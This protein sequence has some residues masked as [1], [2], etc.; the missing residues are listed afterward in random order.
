[1]N[2]SHFGFPAKHHI[3]LGGMGFIGS[4]L[5][6]ELIRLNQ[7]CLVIDNESLGSLENLSPIATHPNLTTIS[8]DALEESTW[9]LASK[10]V[11][12]S[13][14]FVWHLAANSD[15]A[16]GST[17]SSLDVRNTLMST[18]HLSEFITKI[19][20]KGVVFAS[21]SAVYG[22]IN[23][24]DGF[25]EDQQCQP[26][27]YYGAT[28]LA[29]EH[30]L[31]IAT[32]RLSIPLWIF[33]FAN[34]VGSPATHGVI[35][36][37]LQKLSK[38][39]NDLYILG[40]GNQRK[41]YLGVFHLISCML[42]LVGKSKSGVWNM[43]P[44]DNGITVAEI[45][46]LIT[47][48]AAPD[49]KLHFGTDPYGWVGDISIAKMNCFKLENEMRKSLPGSELAVHSAIHDIASQLEISFTCRSV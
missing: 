12:D 17:S 41:T 24:Q 19:N 7:F 14:V 45:A 16:A 1:M 6:I 32:S 27:S 49:A 31:E 2:S 42:T 36:D 37:L 15:I 20:C 8:N 43:G 5:V 39:Q 26:R 4:R 9:Q 48:H 47:E 13:D 33:R 10:W 28:K 44:G 3:V 23:A 46:R 34:I 40:D 30:L 21:S 38:N 29:S 35:Y 25:L 22:D 18:V 11:N